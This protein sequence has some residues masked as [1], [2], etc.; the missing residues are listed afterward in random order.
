MGVSADQLLFHAVQQND[1]RAFDRLYV[2]YWEQ[3]YIRAW[4]RTGDEQTA[5]DIVQ[6][7]F[8]NL[9]ERRG[10][11]LI[12]TSFLQYLS[13][14]LK[15]RLINHFQSEKVKRR[16]LEKVLHRMA[17]LSGGID[18]LAD[19]KHLE[20]ALDDEL[21]KMPKNMKNSLLLRLDNL[22]VKDIALRLDLAEQTV[23]NNLSAASKRLHKNLGSKLNNRELGT[24]IILVQLTHWYKD[25]LLIQLMKK[26]IFKKLLDSYISRTSTEQENQLVEKW[27]NSFD[28]DGGLPAG[29]KD[30]GKRRALRNAMHSGIQ[31]KIDIPARHKFNFYRPAYLKIAVAI[32]LISG[33]GLLFWYKNNSSTPTQNNDFTYI[34]TGASTMK[35]L[36]LPDSSEIW[37]NVASNLHYNRNFNAKQR[38]VVL[39]QGEAFFK[40]KHNPNRPFVVRT[41]ALST[42]V[43]GTSF[44]IRS[45]PGINEVK[46]TVLTGKV[47]VSRKNRLLGL[48]TP[49]QQ[50]VY[51][52]LTAQ[53]SI[54]EMNPGQSNSWIKGKTYL[55]QASF[56]ELALVLKN[57]YGVNLKTSSSKIEKLRFSMLLDQKTPL[58][59]TIKAISGFRNKP[60][61]GKKN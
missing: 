15:Y 4:N 9:W 10:E 37:L 21:E 38:E 19:Y 35:K 49:G 39:D 55:S 8:I 3:M 59:N 18:D 46:I 25:A 45:Y 13:G 60:K 22:S 28:D 47:Q 12:Q 41:G 23:S 20:Q 53:D 51:N 6:E 14:A 56:T 33:I 43:L 31:K 58:E 42:R 48:L 54:H 29:L 11:I 40:V 17:E 61:T 36:T 32:F 50:I 34:S 16:V 57:R 2:M 24:I 44:N 52:K 5:Q 26:Q 30:P 27:Y 1:R 7:L